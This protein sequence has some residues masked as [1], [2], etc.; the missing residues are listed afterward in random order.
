KVHELLSTG[1]LAVPTAARVEVVLQ[2]IVI[3]VGW[4]RLYWVYLNTIVFFVPFDNAGV[5]AI[6]LAA[7]FFGGVTL[8]F[9]GETSAWLLAGGITL[10]ACLCSI[11]YTFN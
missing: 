9:T 6:D 4:W 7:F 1:I 3:A 10:L 2:L 5:F 11:I 8:F